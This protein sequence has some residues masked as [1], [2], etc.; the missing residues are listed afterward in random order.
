MNIRIN[1]AKNLIG[2]LGS[3]ILFNSTSYS[4]PT[5]IDARTQINPNTNLTISSLTAKYGITGGSV[6]ISN[7]MS[8]GSIGVGT[9]N[10]AGGFF[11]AEGSFTRIYLNGG[12][13]LNIDVPTG[14]GSN[15]LDLGGSAAIGS[16][17]AGFLTAPSNGLLVQGNVGISTGNPQMPLDVNGAAQ[18]GLGGIKST[19]TNSGN[20]LVAYNIHS[21][22]ANF[23]S[24]IVAGSG[25]FT[26]GVSVASITLTGSNPT[27]TAA[28][29]LYIATQSITNNVPPTLN[30]S[31]NGVIVG[32]TTVTP[33]SIN[34]FITNGQPGLVLVNWN[35]SGS[36]M[37]GVVAD[38][39]T[40]AGLSLVEEGQG[41]PFITVY[42]A[43]GSISAPG[44]V[45]NG[46]SLLPITGQILDDTNT[47]RTAF[48]L[49]FSMD[50]NGVDHGSF[51][52]NAQLKTTPPGQLNAVVNFIETSTGTLGLGYTTPTSVSQTDRLDV[53]GSI[54]ATGGI[55]ASSA[56]LPNGL[57]VGGSTFTATGSLM[58]P[59]GSTV[60]AQGLIFSTGTTNQ[61]DLVISPDGSVHVNPLDIYT[62]SPSILSQLTQSPGTPPNFSVTWATAGY[63]GVN[64]LYR[65]AIFSVGGSFN[66]AIHNM[67]FGYG[68]PQALSSFRGSYNIDIASGTIDNPQ[69]ITVG[70]T[71]IGEYD[72]RAYGKNAF[73][74][75]A[76]TEAVIE[77][78][79][80]SSSIPSYPT[81]YQIYTTP[82]GSAS[83]VQV[84][85]F[86]ST[87]TLGINTSTP[88]D[89]DKLDVN[90][91]VVIR[92]GIT[93][94]SGTLPNGLTVGG[95]TFTATGSLILP[96]G[97]TISASQL[98][99]STS[100]TAPIP[101]IA[102]NP[103]GQIFMSVG[104][105][106][107]TLTPS[108][109][110]SAFSSG[111]ITG[112]TYT[113]TG[114]TVTFA[115]VTLNSGSLINIGDEISAECVLFSQVSNAVDV[116]SISLN[117]TPQSQHG[118]TGIAQSY[119]LLQL[120]LV[121]IAANQ[122]LTMTTE[123]ASTINTGGFTDAARNE[124]MNVPSV[125]SFSDSSPITLTC[126]GYQPSGSAY[127]FVYFKASKR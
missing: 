91:S 69:P 126:T 28:N 11:D 95:S 123:Y 54:R 13:G 79:G 80:V 72:F 63:S 7:T 20:L 60:T 15:E 104:I 35:G 67:I 92:S 114:T 61:Q 5:Q 38:S 43:T 44:G 78:V 76:K 121:R 105:S 48:G 113:V 108:G 51:P 109:I 73:G 6:T 68:N 127:D 118:L 81:Q 19:F 37:F 111:T 107:N 17:Y 93:A 52:S 42:V 50:A 122:V 27:I 98:N 47:R 96:V 102:L 115:T 1:R 25:T 56:T 66:N 85:V 26:G 22:S 10:P 58:F 77:S 16:G 18:F 99:L 3:L 112:S 53:L 89:T 2:V 75:L 36:R 64:P 4:A 32:T 100:A 29:G 106:S 45:G 9:T 40:N 55:N 83:A 90:G 84:A 71:A 30:I 124:P 65:Q 86:D 14:T 62:S 39:G 87:G 125:Q 120:R 119:L 41:S 21:G 31:T 116:I 46:K 23:T 101:S 49:S 88:S 24:G 33:N 117:G 59:F 110:L 74:L 82:T 12:G 103:D 34:G 57:T 70:N 94:S 8:A 97:S